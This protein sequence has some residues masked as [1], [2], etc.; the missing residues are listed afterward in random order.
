MLFSAQFVCERSMCLVPVCISLL[1]LGTGSSVPSVNFSI[2]SF[3][4]HSFFSSLFSCWRSILNTFAWTVLKNTKATHSFVLHTLPSLTT[5]AYN[6]K[7]RCWLRRRIEAAAT[8][9]ACSIWECVAITV[10]MDD[11]TTT[12][13]HSRNTSARAL[14]HI[15]MWG[16]NG[17][18]R[19]LCVRNFFCFYKFIACF[20]EARKI[21]PAA[22]RAII[23][24]RQR[25]W[26]GGLR[27]QRAGGR[28]AVAQKP[29]MNNNI[30]C[31]V[32]VTRNGNKTPTH[33]FQFFRCRCCWLPFFIF[34]ISLIRFLAHSFIIA[35]PWFRHLLVCTAI[36]AF[37]P[38]PL[39][40]KNPP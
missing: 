26:C 6:F 32:H 40:R 13:V 5:I 12:S 31:A 36:L 11:T 15:R 14:V 3:R 33:L 27:P 2:H 7:L 19:W 10:E 35:R 17:L 21:Q 8:T 24:R 9:M 23:P 38:C 16:R 1:V 29:K 30:F 28:T 25:I 22:D 37:V 4:S 39:W 20:G 18:F 34:F